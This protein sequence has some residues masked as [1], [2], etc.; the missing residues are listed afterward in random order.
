[1]V[2]RYTVEK[3]ILTVLGTKWMLLFHSATCPIVNELSLIP[4]L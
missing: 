3:S 2:L 4:L 1:M